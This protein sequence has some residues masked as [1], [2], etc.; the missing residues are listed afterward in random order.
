MVVGGYDSSRVNGNF[1]TFPVADFSD[2][3]PC[4]LQ[5]NITGLTFSGQSLLN[6]SEV[7]TACIEPYT[8]RS[9]F[10]PDVASAFA[11]VTGQNSTAY[12]K[13]MEYASDETPAGDMT[14][15]LSNGYNTTITNS[16]LFT[17]LRGSDEYGRYAITNTS[18]VEAGVADNRDEDPS[19]QT[20][21]LGGLFLTFN[22]LVVD[23]NQSVFRMAPAV[24]SDVETEMTLKTVCTPTPTPIASSSPVPSSSRYERAVKCRRLVFGLT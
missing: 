18:I 24:A 4:P 3:L 22:Y 14:I 5:V 19:T 17:L 8:Q 21:T 16:E 13:G 1:T 12:P 6:T 9:V 15:T 11:Q 2:D 20:P 23:Y 10:P 7:I